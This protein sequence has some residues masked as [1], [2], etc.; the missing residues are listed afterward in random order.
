VPRY[1]ICALSFRREPFSALTRVPRRRLHL[2]CSLGALNPRH[3]VLDTLRLLLRSP[4]PSPPRA[5]PAAAAPHP[6]L[7]GS[8]FPQAP[9]RRRPTPAAPAPAPHGFGPRRRRFFRRVRCAPSVMLTS[10]D[11]STPMHLTCS[12]VLSS[13]EFRAKI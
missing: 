4:P 11:V 5:P 9:P 1:T 8:S 13:V 2:H 12:C 6:P 3:G 10:D 7:P